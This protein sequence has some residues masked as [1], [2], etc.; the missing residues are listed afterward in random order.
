VYDFH[1]TPT[2]PDNSSFH[3]QLNRRNANIPTDF[4][5]KSDC[6]AAYELKF[7]CSFRDFR[8]VCAGEVSGTDIALSNNVCVSQKRGG[9]EA[10]EAFHSTRMDELSDDELVAATKSGNR[11]AF[12]QLVF[13]YERRALIVARRI[14]NNHEDAEDVVQESFHKAFLHIESFQEKARFSTWLTRIAMNEAYMLL[15]RRRR[16]LE[17]S[18]EN[19]EDGTESIP[20]TFVDQRSNPEQSYWRQERAKLLTSAIDRLSPKLRRTI[21]LYDIEEHSMSETAQILSTTRAAVKS[22][23]NHG[24]KQLR[25]WMNPGQQFAMRAGATSMLARTWNS[26]V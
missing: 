11:E 8:V 20:E 25:G 5:E 7:P 24:H 12:G 1:S 23:L 9:R 2:Q 13:R 18:S 19:A 17:I 15:R 21:L 10:M 22:R 26:R 3:F 14:L 4:R 6:H 16:T